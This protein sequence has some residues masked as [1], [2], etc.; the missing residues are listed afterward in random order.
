LRQAVE[1]ALGEQIDAGRIDDRLARRSVP[2]ASELLRRQAADQLVRRQQGDQAQPAFVRQGHQ[3]RQV[4]AGDR[5]GVRSVVQ[6]RRPFLV[7]KQ[8]RRA[9]RARGR[10]DHRVV[11]GRR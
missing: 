9:R 3:A 11:S 1:R 5:R 10:N 4:F 7:A 6:A 2:A 8:R